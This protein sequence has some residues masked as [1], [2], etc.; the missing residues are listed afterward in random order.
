MKNIKSLFIVTILMVF[1][2]GTTAF[3][4]KINKLD[5]NGKRTGLWEK[6]YP[7]GRL[8]YTGDF[9][10]GKEVGT[11][12]FYRNVSGSI[13]HIIKDFSK[14]SDSAS[15][16][17]FN[18]LGKLKVEGDMIGK[19]RVG[20]WKYYFTNGKLFSEE[21]YNN[22]KLEGLLKNYYSNGNVT[23]ETQYKNGVKN[24]QSKVYT[25][26]GVLIEDVLYVDGKLNG[27]AKYFDLK[28][29]IKQKGLY[30]NGIK[31]GKWEF[32]IDGEVSDKPKRQTHSVPKSN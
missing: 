11:F 32:Y 12:T 17:F 7:N 28:G 9:L 31:E 4:Q 23:E 14:V 21:Y 26:T 2:C 27:E 24:G 16:K 10:A 30:K 25:E 3:S 15:V 22:G 13:P 1:F 18:P 8:R 29:K 20:A 19:S 6:K 5:A